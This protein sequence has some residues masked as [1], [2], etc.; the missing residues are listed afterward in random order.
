MDPPRSR[1]PLGASFI[2][3][4]VALAAA[5][6]PENDLMLS[7]ETETKSLGRLVVAGRVVLNIW[8][9]GDIVCSRLEIGPDGYVSGTIAAREI[10]VEGQ[11]VG[12]I[13]ACSV[14][15]KSG[16]FVEGNVHHTALTLEPGA[17][18][19]GRA[20]R[21]RAIQLPAELLAL[22]AKKAA[23]EEALVQ[24]ERQSV[25]GPPQLA[26]VDGGRTRNRPAGKPENTRHP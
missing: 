19:T 18:L 2:N 9:E 11:V 20:S 22:E 13:H 12:P 3:D 6:P 4:T 23:D 16:A 15:L 21:F 10:V 5:Q 24:A 26:V 7:I 14:H 17:T 25:F 8:F 1:D